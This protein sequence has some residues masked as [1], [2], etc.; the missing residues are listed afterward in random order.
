MKENEP[1]VV[2]KP[3]FVTLHELQANLPRRSLSDAHSTAEFGGHLTTKEAINCPYEHHQAR[4][5]A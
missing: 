2:P 4:C 1:P 3:A 5:R